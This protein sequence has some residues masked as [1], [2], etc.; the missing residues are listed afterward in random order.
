LTAGIV[1]SIDT[2]SGADARVVHEALLQRRG[3]A[4][5]VISRFYYWRGQSMSTGLKKVCALALLCGLALW[6]GVGAG[7]GGRSTSAAISGKITV[8][9]VFFKSFPQYTTG[10][11]A[12]DKAFE[13]QY[14]NVTVEHVAQPYDNYS[15]LLRAAFTARQG[16]DVMMMLPAQAGIMLYTKGLDKLNSRITPDMQKLVGWYAMTPGYTEKTGTRYGVPIGLTDFVF[17]Y[18][19][20]LFKKAGLPAEFKPKSW[21]DLKSAAQKLKAAGITPFVGGD[22]EGY[23]D[24]W[25]WMSAWPTVNT[26]QQAIDLGQGKIPFTSKIVARAFEPLQMMQ[27]A[28]LLQGNRYTTPFFVQGY[29][30]FSKGKGAIVLGGSTAVAYWGEFNKALGAK[31]VG[32]FYSPGAKY[33]NAEPE[34]GWSIPS[35]ADNKEAAWAYISFFASKQGMKLV[36]TKLGEIP[37]R[38]DVPV[39][40][41][42]PKQVHEIVDLYRKNKTFIT[43]AQLF[44]FQVQAAFYAQAPQL[45][46]GRISMAQFQKALQDAFNRSKQ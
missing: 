24:L 44:P 23:E 42:A 30:Q 17:Y 11:P 15:A 39:P 18:N 19:K 16:P 46:Q 32:V 38:K 6:V 29:Q 8:W 37:N 4:E 7:S 36:Y 5:R 3:V 21:N 22:K 26:M 33:V 43:I 28:G 27:K 45:M 31:N 1:S 12:I 41:N 34:F 13:K 25:W 10:M 40:A 20:A 35:F 14:P 2:S 9:D